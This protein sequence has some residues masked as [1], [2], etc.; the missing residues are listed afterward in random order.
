MAPAEETSV[1]T[2]KSDPEE[3]LEET[4]EAEAAEETKQEV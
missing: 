2:G 4:V 1:E 3:P